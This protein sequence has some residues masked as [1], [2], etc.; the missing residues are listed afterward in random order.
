MVME[1]RIKKSIVILR[2]GGDLARGIAIRLQK[3]GIHLVITELA[4]PLAVRR[5]VSFSEAVYEG[6]VVIEGI[7]GRLVDRVV[8]VRKA[9]KQ[10]EVPVLV[11]PELE[12][13]NLLQFDIAAMIDARMR[14]LPP[15]TGL[16]YAPLVIGLGPGFIAGENCHA[17][18]E[19]NRGHYLGRVI[20]DGS[21]EANTGI[22]G[23]VGERQQDRVLRAPINGKLKTLAAIGASLRQGDAIGVVGSELISAPFDGVLRGLLR[24]G[25]PVQ[26]G[27]KVGDLDPRGDPGLAETVSEKSLAIGGGVLE[28]L[29]T[30]RKI[31]EKLWS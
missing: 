16:E 9:L 23:R 2:G 21:A 1:E 17:V 6:E 5:L 19:T 30:R 22:P 25:H 20:W 4:Q 27:M 12:I 14:K 24:N 10:G 26:K 18:I 29:L 7:R 15:E 8:E 11:D 28:A 13:R 31:R 3:V